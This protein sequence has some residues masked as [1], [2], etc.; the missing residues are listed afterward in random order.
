MKK[1]YVKFCSIILFAICSIFIIG[2]VK[3]ESFA[4]G[5]YVSKIYVRKE[6]ENKRMYLRMQWIHR[7]SD[8]AFVYC[9]DPWTILDESVEYSSSNIAF[10]NEISQDIMNKVNLIAYYGYGYGNHQEDYWYVVTQMLIWKTIDPEGDFYFTDSLNGIRVEMFTE[11]FAELE[12]LVNEH[13]VV[14]SLVG[15]LRKISAGQD[16]ELVDTNNVLSKYRIVDNKGVIKSVDEN[17]IVFHSDSSQRI[18]IDLKKEA[19]KYE[20]I[21]LVYKNAYS[22]D[23]YYDGNFNTL[24]TNIMLEFIYGSINLSKKDS[25]TLDLPTNNFVT[26]ENA[27]YEVYDNNNELVGTIVTDS[28][29][30]GTIENLPLGKYTIR[31]KTASYGYN[32]DENTY[33]IELTT[34]NNNQEL[35]VYEDLKLKKLEIFKTYLDTVTN[36]KKAEE[37]VE[38]GIYNKADNRLIATIKTDNNGYAS[39]ELEYG[40][41]II[42]QL[43]TKDGYTKVEDFEIIINADSKNSIKKEL[44]NYPYQIEV[45]LPNT[46]KNEMNLSI[47]ALI[48]VVI[49]IYFWVRKKYVKVK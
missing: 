29:G 42:K 24:N 6:K 33:E 14:P 30:M 43:T 10:Y 20:H 34:E 44:V 4:A 41:Y 38:F 25:N 37:N 23:I 17:K 15:G 40:E 3:A 26:L 2:H 12:K 32:I 31:E 48:L 46:N 9:L 13:Y 22:Q 5:D 19:N 36:N 8:W 1:V 11:Q 18:S 49:K 39:I 16:V 35:T 45:D 7:T 47:L 27:I 28:N 21:P